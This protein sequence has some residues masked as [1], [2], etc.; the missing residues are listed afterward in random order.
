MSASPFGRRESDMEAEHYAALAFHHLRV[1]CALCPWHAEG[2]S[3][4]VLEAQRTHRREHG[5]GRPRHGHRAHLSKVRQAD[6]N[7]DERAAIAASIARRKRLHGIEEA[8]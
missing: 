3:G 5:F 8:A 6:L 2:L 7:E 4:E 1:E